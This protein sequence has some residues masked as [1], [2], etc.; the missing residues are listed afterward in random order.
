MDEL[1]RF[2]SERESEIE[3]LCNSNHQ[4][5]VSSVNQLLN[6]RR[7]TADLTKEILKPNQSIQKSTGKLVEQKKALVDSRDL[8][9]NIGEATQA[10]RLCLEVLGLANRVGDLLKQKTHYV[11]LGAL[12]EFKNCCGYDTEV[13]S[14]DARDGERSSYDRLE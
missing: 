10:L 2:S 9:Q 11:A 6:V 3:R 14:C 12:D 13:G 8:R 1:G 4:D 7:G 5:F